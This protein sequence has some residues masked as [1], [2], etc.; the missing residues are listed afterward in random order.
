MPIKFLV[1]GL[2]RFNS[3]L[4]QVMFLQWVVIRYLKYNDVETHG[5]P[6]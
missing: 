5:F 2:D 1:N 3:G 4:F 6:I